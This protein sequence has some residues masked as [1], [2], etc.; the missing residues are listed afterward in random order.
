MIR[1]PPRSTLFPYT[2]LFRSPVRI[3]GLKGVP[4]VSDLLQ[5]FAS[6][7]EAKAEV[8]NIRK[9]KKISSLVNIKKIGIEELSES[10]RDSEKKELSVVLK[11][12]VRGSLDAIKEA[13]KNISNEEV[14][15]KV[16][17]GKVGDITEN[18]IAMAKSADNIIIGF[19]VSEIGRAHV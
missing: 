18:D 5:A 2:T 8:E 19:N 17:S 4:K 10:M 11:T 9:T 7:K 16:I 14:R 6:E 1:R 13:F 15:I 12:D 3:S